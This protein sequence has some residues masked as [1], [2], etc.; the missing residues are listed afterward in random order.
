MTAVTAESESREI[1]CFAQAEDFERASEAVICRHC[2][3]SLPVGCHR[4]ADASAENQATARD[5]T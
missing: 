2:R 3:H 5:R 4:G 1:D